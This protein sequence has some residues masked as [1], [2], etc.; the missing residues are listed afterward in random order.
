MWSVVMLL[1][2]IAAVVLSIDK[3]AETVRWLVVGSIFVLCCVTAWFHGLKWARDN[4]P[5]RLP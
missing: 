2:A 4:P 1:L 5:R 3:G